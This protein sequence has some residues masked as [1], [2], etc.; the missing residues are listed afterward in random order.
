MNHKRI[1]STHMSGST[2]SW[3]LTHKLIPSIVSVVTVSRSAVVDASGTGS[4]GSSIDI[5]FNNVSA[6]IIRI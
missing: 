2:Y 3:F 6:F 5:V 1:L 4:I